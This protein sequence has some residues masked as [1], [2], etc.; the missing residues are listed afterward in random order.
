[1]AASSINL[2][3]SVALFHGWSLTV[4]RVQR[5]TSRRQFYQSVP[6]ISWYSFNLPAEDER[7]SQ[8]WSDSVVLSLRPIDWESGAL[9]ATPLLHRKTVLIKT[10][11]E[12]NE[13]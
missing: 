7:L 2:K 1:M 4:S 12:N 5:A 9:T 10:A 6:K 8:P 11:H 13:N 3:N